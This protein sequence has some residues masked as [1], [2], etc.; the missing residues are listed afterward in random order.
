MGPFKPLK[1]QRDNGVDLDRWPI[2]TTYLE[3]MLVVLVILMVTAPLLT[4]GVPVD[5]P[6]THP[7]AINERNLLPLR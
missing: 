4:V 6:K 5:L 7:A 3:V 2:L 1:E